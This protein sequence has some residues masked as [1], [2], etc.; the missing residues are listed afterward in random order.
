MPEKKGSKPTAVN[1]WAMLYKFQNEQASIRRKSPGEKRAEERAKWRKEL[2]D[3]VNHKRSVKERSRKNDLKYKTIIDEDIK[4]WKIE[5]KKQKKN[6]SIEKY[7]KIGIERKRQLAERQRLQS[8][9]DEEQ[10]DIETEMMRRREREIREIEL[11]KQRRRKWQA[12]ELERIKVANE[13][14]LERKARLR[15]EQFA[16]EAKLDAQWK[17]ILDKQ[18]RA[19][20]MQLEEL[21]KKQHRMVK[22]AQVQPSQLLKT[23]LQKINDEQSIGSKSRKKG[24]GGRPRRRGED[25]PIKTRDEKIH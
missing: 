18:E 23:S 4:R 2:L 11:E 3:A 24:A 10:K 15:Q 21:Y 8:L 6:A 12:A 13:E 22:I 7:K 20:K 14:V 25:S 16:Y 1:E 9:R 19:R 5:E 17:E